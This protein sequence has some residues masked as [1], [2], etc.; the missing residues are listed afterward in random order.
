MKRYCQRQFDGAGDNDAET[1]T[2]LGEEGAEASV[3]LSVLALLS[4][5]AIG[6]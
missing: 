5:V 1:H 4:E 2:G 3:G 6:L